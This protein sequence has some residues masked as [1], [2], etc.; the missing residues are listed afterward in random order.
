MGSYAWAAPYVDLLY[1]AGVI[2]G[3]GGQRYRPAD[4]VSR[5]ISC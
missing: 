5:G 3:T 2:T 4:A 1:E